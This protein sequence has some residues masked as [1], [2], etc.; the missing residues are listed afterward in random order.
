MQFGE[1]AAVEKG[2]NPEMNQFNNALRKVLS[3]SKTDLQKLLA[4]EKASK[5]GKQKPGPK[6]RNDT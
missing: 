5:V 1:A 6:K 4:E 2:S 3:L